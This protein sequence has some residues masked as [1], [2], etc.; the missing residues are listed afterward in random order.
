MNN[1]TIFAV[2]IQSINSAKAVSAIA[3]SY[4]YTTSPNPNGINIAHFLIFDKVEKTVNAF[5]HLSYF[6]DFSRKKVSH[7]IRNVSDLIDELEKKVVE[8]KVFTDDKNIEFDKNGFVIFNKNGFILSNTAFEQLVNERNEFIGK[9]EK[10]RL[11]PIVT[12]T[13][14]SN[15]TGVQ[16]RK[17]AVIEVTEDS[18]SGLDLK[19]NNKFKKFSKIN[20]LS[21]ISFQGFTED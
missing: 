20:M 1:N 5:N 16:A 17:V 2:E 18:V 12:F 4:G 19:D 11:L 6:N 8:R 21:M 10:K 3:K 7:V 13:Y 15:S 14:Q 9:K